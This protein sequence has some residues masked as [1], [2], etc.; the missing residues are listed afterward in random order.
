MARAQQQAMPVVGFLGSASAD[1]TPHFVAAFH[2]GL[3][4]WLHER[5]RMSQPPFSMKESCC[6]ELTFFSSSRFARAPVTLKRI[7]PNIWTRLR[8]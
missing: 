7:G 4:S 8:T 6:H 3:G 2:K 1:T 5:A